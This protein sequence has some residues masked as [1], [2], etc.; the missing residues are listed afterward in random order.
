MNR[1]IDLIRDIDWASAFEKELMFSGKVDA[2]FV[3]SKAFAS[4]CSVT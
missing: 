3:S 4:N 1:K 2:S